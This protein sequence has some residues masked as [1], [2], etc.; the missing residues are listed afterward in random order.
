MF[1]VRKQV[2][3]I[4]RSLSVTFLI[5]ITASC[6]IGVDH[7]PLHRWW[8]FEDHGDKPGTGFVLLERGGKIEG[9]HFFILMPFSPDDESGRFFKMSKIKQDGKLVTAVIKSLEG[10]PDI[11]HSKLQIKLLDDFTGAKRVR[12]E[13]TDPERE[14]SAQRTQNVVFVLQGDDWDNPK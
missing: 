14:R 11:G 8:A 2:K 3:P 4:R 10:D 9:G 6:V 13:I 12:G 1:S 7:V 5:L